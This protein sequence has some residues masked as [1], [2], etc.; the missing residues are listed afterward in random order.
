VTRDERFKIPQKIRSVFS[1]FP[2]FNQDRLI[3]GIA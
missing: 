2:D 1:N 3:E